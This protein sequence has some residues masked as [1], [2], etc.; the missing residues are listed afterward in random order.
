MAN[1]YVSFGAELTCRGVEIPEKISASENDRQRL[2]ARRLFRPQAAPVLP[3]LDAGDERLSIVWIDVCRDVTAPDCAQVL[4]RLCGSL[5][6]RAST[7]ECRESAPTQTVRILSD[8]NSARQ[9]SPKL[10]RI[11]IAF[12]LTI[13]RNSK[14]VL[15][16]SY[17]LM[18]F[19]AI[20]S[21]LARTLGDDSTRILP[22]FP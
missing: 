5:D 2:V 22:I 12:L 13:S 8:R 10:S 6:M 20:C 3:P 9:A 21:A 1:T 16:G 15:F 7:K 18:I 4:G 11:S 19:C 14:N 17:M